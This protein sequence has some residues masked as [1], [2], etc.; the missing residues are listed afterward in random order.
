MPKLK[1]GERI[2]SGGR[3][4]C[5]TVGGQFYVTLRKPW[6]TYYIGGLPEVDQLILDLQAIRKIMVEEKK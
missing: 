1:K 6:H 3:I 5:A 4:C 2:V